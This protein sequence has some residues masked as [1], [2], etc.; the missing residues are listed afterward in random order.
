MPTYIAML[1]WTAF[2]V[3]DL[4]VRAMIG[5]SH[6]IWAKRMAE[7]AVSVRLEIGAGR[8]HLALPA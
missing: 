8:S 3:R 7:A 6:R 1:K 5:V 4:R 2:R